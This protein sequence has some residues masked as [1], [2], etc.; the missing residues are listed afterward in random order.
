MKSIACALLS[1]LPPL[2]AADTIM[3]H[4]TALTTYIE[5]L[6]THS[7]AQIAPCVTEDAVFIFTEDTFVGK[8]AAKAAFEKTVKL[9]ENEVFSLHDIAWTAVTDDVATC[10]YEFRWKG[11]ISGLEASGGGRGTSILRKVDGRWLIAHE[12]LGPY[13]RK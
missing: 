9:I 3:N 12:H 13:P 2:S 4:E 6:N 1:L 10:H 11:L 7:W 8:A 5:K